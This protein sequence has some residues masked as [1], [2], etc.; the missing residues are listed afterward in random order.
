MVLFCGSGSTGAIHT[1]IDCL[2]LRIPA[3]L[4]DRYGFTERIPPAERPVVFIGPYEHHSNELPWR[5]S[6]AELVTVPEDHDGRID[7][8][9]LER[10]LIA[11]ADRPVKIGSFSAASNVTGILSDVRAISVL[12]HRYGALSCWD[13]AAAAPYV[14]IEMAP[15]GGD[16]DTE[17]DYKDAVFVSPHKFV[18]GPGTP[19]VLVARRSLFRNRV[20][21]VPGGGTVAYVNPDRAPLPRR[22]RAPRGG[23]HSRDRRVDPRRARLP[24]EGGRRDRGDPRP[25]GVLH[26][27]RDAPVGGEPRT[28]RSSGATT[29]PG[30]RSCRSS[31]VT[32][33]GTCTT[34]SS[35]R[36]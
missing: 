35:W 34:T 27:P 33:A 21:S 19:G 12:L 11:Y 1:L 2:E 17:L 18:G 28:S 9:A 23:R 15:H 8:E 31:C 30:C 16:A 7:L 25:G 29:C 14:D 22:H 3:G 13:F 36:S 4:D 6:I 26:A 32:T 5:E 10:E 24:A 20:P